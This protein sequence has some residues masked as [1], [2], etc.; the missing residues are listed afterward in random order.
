MDIE[1]IEFM[2][3][4]DDNEN[5][6]RKIKEIENVNTRYHGGRTL[7]MMCCHKTTNKPYM[8]K[9]LINKFPDIDPEI[10]DD[11][12]STAL[13]YA[14]ISGDKRNVKLMLDGFPN[15]DVNVSGGEYKTTPL[16]ITCLHNNTS[17]I[18]LLLTKE[19]IKV[20]VRDSRGLYPLIYALFNGNAKVV[21]MLLDRG[22]MLDLSKKLEHASYNML[23]D[24]FNL[25]KECLIL[26]EHFDNFDDFIQINKRFTLENSKDE[27]LLDY[28][29][30][31]S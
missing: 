23:R 11:D 18:E 8:L 15:I 29:N 7:L 25:N 31:M 10:P 16:I 24:K 20:N 6:N 2:C 19:N 1:K 14:C 26:L 21:K 28:I 9:T 4:H 27:V 22:A 17:I 5:F 30:N 12:G 3:Y 13:M